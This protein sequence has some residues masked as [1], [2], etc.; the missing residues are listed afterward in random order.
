M[1]AM[2]S[3]PATHTLPPLTILAHKS[4]LLSS[5][6]SLSQ[7]RSTL[8]ISRARTVL[9]RELEKR[10]A[11]Q[12]GGVGV[13][14]LGS[15]GEGTEMGGLECRSSTFKFAEWEGGEVHF[16]STWTRVAGPERA[17]KHEREKSNEDVD[18]LDDFRLWLD[19]LP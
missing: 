14:G 10:R 11:A 4:D 13:E 6:S 7:D 1:H 18:G 9:E 15:E 19:D 12:S 8:A 2:T 17:E 5:S 16:M 3:L